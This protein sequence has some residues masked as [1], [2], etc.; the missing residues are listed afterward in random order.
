MDGSKPLHVRRSSSLISLFVYAWWLQPRR[1][2]TIHAIS[3]FLF[4]CT[5]SRRTRG[6]TAVEDVLLRSC[7]VGG[8]SLFHHGLVP[9]DA[10][11]VVLRARDYGVAAVVKCARK[12]VVLMPV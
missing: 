3:S 11:C 9:P 5:T 10:A 7:C 6:R 12:Y 4:L 2:L 1:R 8:G